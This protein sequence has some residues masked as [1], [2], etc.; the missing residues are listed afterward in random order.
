MGILLVAIVLWCSPLLWGVL[1]KITVSQI[2]K[3]SWLKYVLIIVL[4]VLPVVL[5]YSYM[6]LS[7]MKLD[8]TSVLRSYTGYYWKVLYLPLNALVVIGGGLLFVY[9]VLRFL[10][11]RISQME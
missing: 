3:L 5:I 7:G 11:K 6:F 8:D 1:V 10:V 4:G 9:Q 2:V